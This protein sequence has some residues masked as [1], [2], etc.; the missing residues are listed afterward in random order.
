[1]RRRAI[2]SDLIN[3]AGKSDPCRPA[4]ERSGGG[5]ATVLEAAGDNRSAR[6][7]D[8][9]NDQHRYRRTLDLGRRVVPQPC[10]ETG[11]IQQP[12]HTQPR[13]TGDFVAP[14]GGAVRACRGAK[15]DVV[16][17]R[18]IRLRGPCREPGRRCSHNVPASRC[19]HPGL[20]SICRGFATDPSWPPD[21]STPA[22]TRQVPSGRTFDVTARASASS[23]VPP[24]HCNLTLQLLPVRLFWLNPAGLISRP[25]FR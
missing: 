22:D 8:L 21:R 2:K 3:C 4:M 18:G 17:R 13:Q 19:R 12:R 11:F 25:N 23:V 14:G 10:I 7:Q 15:H 16:A 6:I 1:M 20:Q 9:L 24:P 5:A